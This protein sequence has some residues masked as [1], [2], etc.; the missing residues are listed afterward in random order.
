MRGT[1][2]RSGVPFGRDEVYISVT[3]QVNVLSVLVDIQ[4]WSTGE[5]PGQKIWELS[6]YIQHRWYSKHFS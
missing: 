6:V 2:G 1:W 3:H 5:S 4:V